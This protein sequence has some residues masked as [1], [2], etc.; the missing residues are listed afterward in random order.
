MSKKHLLITTPFPSALAS[1]KLPNVKFIDCPK[2]LSTK[3]DKCQKIIFK[4]KG[5]VRLAG[6]NY[7]KGSEDIMEGQLLKNDGLG[8]FK[9]M[10]NTRVSVTTKE[11]HRALVR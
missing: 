1:I 11:N 2:D 5:K 9:K 4:K 8:N 3:Y 10:I 7:Y 6:L